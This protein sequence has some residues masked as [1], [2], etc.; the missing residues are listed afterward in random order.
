MSRPRNFPVHRVLTVAELP[1]VDAPAIAFV[2]ETGKWYFRHAD[3]R[4]GLGGWT[5]Y[6]NVKFCEDRPAVEVSG[7]P[8][9]RIAQYFETFFGL[10]THTDLPG[11]INVNSQDVLLMTPE[12][13]RALYNGTP[14]LGVQRPEAKTEQW[15]LHLEP[16]SYCVLHAAAQGA[17][18]VSMPMGP[19]RVPRFNYHPNYRLPGGQYCST[20]AGCYLE[21][22]VPTFKGPISA[23]VSA[24]KNGACVLSLGQGTSEPLYMLGL[25][26]FSESRLISWAPMGP[27][28]AD[29]LTKGLVNARSIPIAPIK[30]GTGE[31]AEI[32]SP[33]E[34]TLVI[35]AGKRPGQPSGLQL[36]KVGDYVRL[37]DQTSYHRVIGGTFHTTPPISHGLRY[38]IYE[39]PRELIVSPGFS[40]GAP[41]WEVVH[42]YAGK[43]RNY[44]TYYSGT[45][46]VPIKYASNGTLGL[47]APLPCAI[48]EGLYR[49]VADKDVM[50]AAFRYLDPS[51]FVYGEEYDRTIFDT[52]IYTLTV[53][54]QRLV[55]AW[56]RAKEEALNVYWDS[57]HK[58]NPD[59]NDW[60]PREFEKY[61]STFETVSQTLAQRLSELHI[62]RRYQH[63]L[64][65]YYS[66]LQY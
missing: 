26:P 62:A 54:Q 45:V 42:G 9:T 36:V 66:L 13:V 12:P 17:M 38:A 3:E 4:V 48:P 21:V 63:P 65:N 53:D 27:A 18:A 16:L 43:G 6:E 61:G 55:L 51:F 11:N 30:I 60:F 56:Q 39:D 14:G 37:G 44:T 8:A 19:K 41:K 7:P 20:F 57:E 49:I 29:P 22:E 50:T 1:T 15:D 31:T 28:T 2:R 34:D 5:D 35:R 32:T 25:W 52:A 40:A 59:L 46:R 33:G 24:F 47:G 58:I 23:Q 64:L 10:P